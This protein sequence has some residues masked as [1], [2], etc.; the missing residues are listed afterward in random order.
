MELGEQGAPSTPAVPEAQEPSPGNPGG[1]AGPASTNACKDIWGTLWSPAHHPPRRLSPEALAHSGTGTPT[2]QPP[3]HR[4]RGQGGGGEDTGFDIRSPVVTRHAPWS[5]VTSEPCELGM[6]PSRGPG[7][8]GAQGSRQ[9]CLPPACISLRAA[10]SPQKHP[11]PRPCCPSLGSQ[12][13]GGQQPPRA[14]AQCEEHG[15]GAEPYVAVIHRGPREAWGT[16]RPWGA[17]RTLHGGRESSSQSRSQPGRRH[18]TGRQLWAPRP[19][20]SELSLPE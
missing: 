5:H 19:C 12:W 11:L 3:T 18:W 14:R 10:S 8:S 16:R 17:R 13:Q 4:T 20:K 9:P 1:P 15:G 7:G 6:S 2:P